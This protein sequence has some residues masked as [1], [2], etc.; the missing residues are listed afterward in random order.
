MERNAETAEKEKQEDKKVS[1]KN[2]LLSKRIKG[3]NPE[4]SRRRERRYS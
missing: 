1:D 2:K 4:K 3:E